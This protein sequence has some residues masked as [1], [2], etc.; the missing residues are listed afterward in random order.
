MG[1]VCPPGDRNITQSSGIALPGRSYWHLSFLYF[2]GLC[3][4]LV[5]LALLSVA[6]Y[7]AAILPYWS[8]YL[9]A[10]LATIIFGGAG[11]SWS[12]WLG[13]RSLTSSFR[14]GVRRPDDHRE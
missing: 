6:T 8:A 12:G 13:S 4:H 7:R 9:V 11:W 2:A 3:L 10:A 5:G 14:E 1:R